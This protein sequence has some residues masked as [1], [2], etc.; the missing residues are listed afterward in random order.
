[1]H[2]SAPS[3][4]TTLRLTPRFACAL[5]AD[6]PS[7]GLS[8]CSLLEQKEPK[9]PATKKLPSVPITL[10]PNSP[11]SAHCTYFLD[12]SPSSVPVL[13]ITTNLILGDSAPSPAIS[14]RFVRFVPASALLLVVSCSLE[15]AGPTI[16]RATERSE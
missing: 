3:H 1:M 8:S 9:S 15:S 4:P 5:A 11:S 12:L 10:T 2:L 13:V 16:L 14:K 6:P 7:A